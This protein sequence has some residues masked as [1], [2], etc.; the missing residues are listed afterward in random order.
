MKPSLNLTLALESE[1]DCLIYRKYFANQNQ[2][3]ISPLNILN[4]LKDEKKYDVLILPTSNCY[5]LAS[6]FGSTQEIFTY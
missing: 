1:T 3:V 6:L 2:I 5:G 4:S